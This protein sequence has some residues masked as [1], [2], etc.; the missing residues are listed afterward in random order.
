MFCK[1][2]LE[3]RYLYI[4]RVVQIVCLCFLGLGSGQ[5]VLAQDSQSFHE[6][7]NGDSKQQ[8]EAIL[9]IIEMQR[10][11]RA[12]SVQLYEIACNK[13][14]SDEIRIAAIEAI[15]ALT[16]PFALDQARVGGYSESWVKKIATESNPLSSEE[17]SLANIILDPSESTKLRDR[18]MEMLARSAM[19]YEHIAIPA[20]IASILLDKTTANDLR[21]KAAECL[22]ARTA[23]PALVREALSDVLSNKQTSIQLR[24][25]CLQSLTGLAMSN[26]N[27][28]VSVKATVSALEDV[29]LIARNPQESKVL[30][31]FALDQLFLALNFPGVVRNAAR[32]KCLKDM[33]PWIT[34]LMNDAKED[35]E[36]RDVARSLHRIAE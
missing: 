6:G 15:G 22:A 27:D 30:R 29:S 36:L 3:V 11:I 32:Q 19:K 1:K 20:L 16:I 14:Q 35:Q 4:L 8:L 25:H 18:A 28:D 17:A 34:Q 2:F 21:M 23:E 5:S 9:A 33:R 24:E 12:A 13:Q 10:Q 7:L 31:K 26:G